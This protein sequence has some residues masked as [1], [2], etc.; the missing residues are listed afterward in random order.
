MRGKIDQAKG[1]LKEA[2]GSLTG[3]KDLKRG[4]RTDRLAGEA[5][6]NVGHATDKTEAVIDKAKDSIQAK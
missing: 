5:K 6:T 3:N 2:M 1:R 4:G